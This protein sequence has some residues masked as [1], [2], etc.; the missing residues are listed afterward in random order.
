[1][2]EIDIEPEISENSFL[3]NSSFIDESIE[4]PHY[5]LFQICPN[6]Q[7]S[8]EKSLVIASVAGSQGQTQFGIIPYISSAV[9][10]KYLPMNTHVYKVHLLSM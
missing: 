2:E 4:V 7:L 9:L 3:G 10:N 6:F 8:L 5:K 1:M